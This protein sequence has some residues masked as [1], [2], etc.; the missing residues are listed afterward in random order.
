[1]RRI[2]HAVR[3]LKWLE[4]IDKLKTDKSH[5]SRGAWI[6]ITLYTDV[7]IS[8]LVA[9]LTR[10][11]DWNFKFWETS[12]RAFVSHRSRG[13]WI[14]IHFRIIRKSDISRSHRSRGVLI[15][16]GALI[17][18]YSLIVW[19]C[20]SSNVLIIMI[21]CCFLLDWKKLARC[22]IYFVVGIIRK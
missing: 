3:G 21:A 9:S 2:A 7:R 11:V 10:C 19:I 1:M 5:R 12:Y 17:S 13:A 18:A 4:A 8:D 16:I 6:E 20:T 14:E 22:K 15:E